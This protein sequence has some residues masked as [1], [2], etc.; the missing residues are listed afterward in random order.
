MICEVAAGVTRN[1]VYETS[2]GHYTVFTYRG[3][4]LIGEEINISAGAVMTNYGINVE[5]FA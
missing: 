2:D 5:V 4:D 1:K 3:S